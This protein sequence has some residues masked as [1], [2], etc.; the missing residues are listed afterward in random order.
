MVENP[1][2]ESQPI[3]ICHFQGGSSYLNN[4]A[5]SRL[6]FGTIAGGT[7]L[8]PPKSRND[9]SE[10]K[11]YQRKKDIDDLISKYAKKKSNSKLGTIQS[12]REMND[13]SSV[14]Y[15]QP[16]SDRTYGGTSS[17]TFAGRRSSQYDSISKTLPNSNIGTN[18]D[19]ATSGKRDSSLNKYGATDYRRGSN[20]SIT[21]NDYRMNNNIYGDKYDK[22]SNIGSGYGVVGSSG[23]GGLSTSASSANIYAPVASNPPPSAA[24]RYL[25]QSKS[26][27][28][29]FLYPQSNNISSTLNSQP[30]HTKKTPL[31]RAQKTLSIH[32]LPGSGSSPLSQKGGILPSGGSSSALLA[33]LRNN[34]DDFYFEGDLGLDNSNNPDWRKKP[35]WNK[36]II[37]MAPPPKIVP[38]P[39]MPVLICF[40]TASFRFVILSACILS[41]AFICN[42]NSLTKVLS[43]FHLKSILCLEIFL[44]LY[45]C[46][47]ICK[48]NI[49][50]PHIIF[51]DINEPKRRVTSMPV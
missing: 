17:N 8:Y 49:F 27:S 4:S 2:V 6:G 11:E 3:T 15:G 22:Y 9:N 7:S 28:N 23:L 32:G 21:G 51:R 43:S 14:K 34:Q 24:R 46:F 50:I 40:E 1:I 48:T 18:Y 45:Q 42:T 12:N 31:S 30:D 35:L 33:Q 39:I 41:K 5:S 38:P 20:A 26:S 25:A 47:M 19:I 29:L 13:Y 37:P 16:N 44:L 10:D 36:N